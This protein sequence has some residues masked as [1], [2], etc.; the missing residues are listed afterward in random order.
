MSVTL[1]DG[2]ERRR[3]ASLRATCEILLAQ[4]TRRKQMDCERRN[5][6]IGRL[7]HTTY[8]SRTIR[9][10]GGAG[11]QAGRQVGEEASRRGRVGGA[12]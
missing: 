2:F 4:H 6:A 10:G 1:Q 12:E 9:G 7:H 8:S 5:A 3:A 11:R